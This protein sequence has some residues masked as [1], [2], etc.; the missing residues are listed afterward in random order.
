MFHYI[1]GHSS[2]PLDCLYRCRHVEMWN[3]IDLLT[4]NHQSYRH[5]TIKTDNFFSTRNPN[6]KR[7]QNFEKKSK[8]SICFQ[9]C[10][11][12]IFKMGVTNIFIKIRVKNIMETTNKQCRNQRQRHPYFRKKPHSAENRVPQKTAFR[13]LK[14]KFVRHEPSQILSHMHLTQ[15][16]KNICNLGR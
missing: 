12:Y 11:Q 1:L 2:T 7:N 16:N 9:K 10:H 14:S 8:I 6:L 5:E 15:L 3:F 4:L 13:A